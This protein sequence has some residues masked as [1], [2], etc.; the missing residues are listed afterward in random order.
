M[1]SITSKWPVF[2]YVTS[3]YV[4]FFEVPPEYPEITFETPRIFSNDS[5]I[6]QKH[7]PAK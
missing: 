3:L 4:G 5:S 2:P 1:T 7:P 6:H